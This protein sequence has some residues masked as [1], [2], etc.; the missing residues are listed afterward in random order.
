MVNIRIVG[1][2]KTDDFV[3]VEKA[4]NKAAVDAT[5]SYQDKTVRCE[6]YDA[7]EAMAAIHAIGLTPSLI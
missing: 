1:S 5:I 4:L 3:K 6:D 2:Q 7:E